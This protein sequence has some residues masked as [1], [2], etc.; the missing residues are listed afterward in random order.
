M[1]STEQPS[2]IEITPI[3]AHIARN[4]IV[5]LAVYVTLGMPPKRAER[6]TRIEHFDNASAT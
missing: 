4:A 1:L 5:A 3:R 6:R 2:G